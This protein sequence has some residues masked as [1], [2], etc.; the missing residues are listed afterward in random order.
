MPSHLLNFSDRSRKHLPFELLT[1]KASCFSQKK[2]KIK[3]ESK[4]MGN[5]KLLHLNWLAHVFIHW[6][7]FQQDNDRRGNYWRTAWAALAGCSEVP[8]TC[9]QEGSCAW[10]LLPRLVTALH[11]TQLPPFFTLHRPRWIFLYFVP[12]PSGDKQHRLSCDMSEGKRLWN[13]TVFSTG[14]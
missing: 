1:P 5:N 11:R 4:I 2:K 9:S 14:A 7:V 13:V 10:V 6:S 8:Q 3:C 12:M